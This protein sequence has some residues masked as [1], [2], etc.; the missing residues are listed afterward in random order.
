MT[1][2]GVYDIFLAA[3]SPAPVVN[4]KYSGLLSVSEASSNLSLVITLDQSSSQ[5]TVVTLGS[6]GSAT[7]GLD[8]ALPA[9]VTIPPGGTSAGTTLVIFD[10]NL[11]E[12]D[13]T[14]SIQLNTTSQ[15][16]AGVSREVAITILDNDPYPAVSLN[17]LGSP[18]AENLGVGYVI[19]LLSN[20]S[21]QDVTVN[22]TFS[23]TATNNVDYSASQASIL[24]LAGDTSGSITLTGVDDTTIEGSEAAVIDVFSVASGIEDGFQ[25]VVVT[26]AD[27]DNSSPVNTVPSSQSVNE[28]TALVIGGISISD[29][30]AGTANVSV[31]LSV[32]HGSITV[33]TNIGGGVTGGQIASNGSGSVTITAPLS[34]INATLASATGVTY[35]G[36]LNFNGAD[37]LTVTTNDLGN[38]GAGG[39]LTDTDTVAITVNAVNDGPTGVN[40]LLSSIAEDS[41]NYTIPFASLLGNDST[42]PTNESGQALTIT[43]VGSTVGGT[44]TIVG[45]NVIFTPT[46]NYNGPA[47]FSY[48]LRDNGTTN[49]IADP[50]SATATA[51]F[52]ITEVNDAPVVSPTISARSRVPRRSRLRRYSATTVKAQPTRAVRHSWSPRLVRPSVVLWGSQGVT[53]SLRRRR[54]TPDQEVSSIPCR[55]TAPPIA[56]WMPRPP[57]RPR[58]S[59]SQQPASRLTPAS[60]SRQLTLMDLQPT[61][62]IR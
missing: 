24:I 44:V 1:G 7:S 38:S 36:T 20:P 26:I 28:D 31:T 5:P 43:N 29:V 10:D 25:Q 46:A 27:D 9:Q 16:T 18:I 47:S 62:A 55:T 60:P 15:G 23:G 6:S 49:L 2:Q 4:L 34:A 61:S 8:Y 32:A 39:A 13:E 22:L 33:A 21:T 54:V 12:G 48:T 57:R 58:A 37:T 56:F 14:V 53:S 19:A 11:F 42:G 35:L 30:D 17:L 40:D 52:T 41:G 59:R 51:S 50:K 45:S 3:L